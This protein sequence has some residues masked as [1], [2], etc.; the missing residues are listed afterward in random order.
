MASTTTPLPA[1]SLETNKVTGVSRLQ[2]TGYF[3]AFIALGLSTGS[4]G[5][6]LAGLAQHTG[7]TLAAISI[8][9]TARSFGYMVGSLVSG[10]AYDRMKGHPVIAIGFALMVAMFIAAPLISQLWLLVL[11]MFVVSLADGAVDVGGNT[12]LVWTIKGNITPFMNALHLFF[13]IGAFVAPILV[14]QSI[15][16]TGDIN[17]AYWAIALLVLPLLVWHL[18]VPSPAH[19]T[20]ESAGAE[21]RPATNTV[22]V[23]LIALYFFL[24][25]GMEITFGGWIASYAVAVGYGDEAAAAVLTSAFWGALMVGRIISIPIGSRFKPSTILWADFIMCALFV[26]LMLMGHGETWALWVGTIGVGMSMASMFPTM[27]SYAETRMKITGKVTSIFLTGSSI[28]GMTLPLF[29][30]Q[31]FESAGPQIM[32]WVVLVTTILTALSYVMVTVVAN[33]KTLER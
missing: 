25:V 20:A 30:G 16:I 28:G 5:P 2:V 23:L 15:T 22:L 11:V 8:V 9:F 18:R 14:A 3:L 33:R 13:G 12:L 29:T 17:W 10:R 27:I 4:V 24:Y 19:P 6:S 21:S 7:S 1:S 26:V 31:V 32:L